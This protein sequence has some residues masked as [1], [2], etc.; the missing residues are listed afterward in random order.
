MAD[1]KLGTV[2]HYFDH[3]QV[4]IVEVESPF[5]VGDKIKFVKNG[6]ELFQQEVASI[7]E[8]HKQ[9]DKTKKGQSVGV[10][11]DQKVH[12]GVEVYEV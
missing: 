8:E 12:E 4:A 1:Q 5:S 11:V 7:Q 3:I 9:L 2:S 10:K 6:E